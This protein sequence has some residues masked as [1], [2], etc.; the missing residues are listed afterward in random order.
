MRRS[1]V[2]VASAALAA[3]TA[4]GFRAAA[5]P[6]G[7]T[8]TAPATTSTWTI[9]CVPI[10]PTIT[11]QWLPPLTCMPDISGPSPGAPQC[12]AKGRP[13]KGSTG[14]CSGTIE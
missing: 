8:T 9:P 4:G 2:V 14:P 3:A 11:S 13:P 6:T 5:Q 1:V 12:D 10:S 7:P